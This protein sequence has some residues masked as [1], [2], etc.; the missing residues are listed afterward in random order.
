MFTLTERLGTLGL[1]IGILCFAVACGNDSPTR[2]TAVLSS[3]PAAPAVT[4]ATITGTV[5]GLNA[6]ASGAF[7]PLSVAPSLVVSVVGTDASTPVDANGAFTLNGVPPSDVSLRFEGQG[8]DATLALGVVQS[9][10]RVHIN[11]TVSGTTAMLDMQQR[12]GGDNKVE[13][14]GRIDDIDPAAQKTLL[15]GTVV[16]VLS[17]AVLRRIDTPITFGDLRRGDRAHVRGV[18]EDQEIRASEVIVQN[19]LSPVPVTFSGTVASVGGSCPT[20]TIGLSGVSGLSV[21][22]VTP[23]TATTTVVTNATTSFPEN[24]CTAIEAGDTASVAGTRQTD[25][26]ILATKVEAQ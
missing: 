10:E 12:I 24:A 19:E 18:R 14:E 6:S 17:D 22:S 8:V 2:P 9:Q 4:G 11:V 13:A 25:G 21:M 5:S 26:R 23:Y 15:G 20:L 3:V 7:A 1:F 16:E